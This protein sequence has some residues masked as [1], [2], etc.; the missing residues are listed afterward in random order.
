MP[1]V[2]GYLANM[3]EGERNKLIMPELMALDKKRKGKL[4]RAIGAERP[5]IAG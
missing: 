4:S 3:S 2:F 5:L 1:D